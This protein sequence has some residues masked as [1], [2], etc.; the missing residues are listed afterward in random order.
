MKKKYEKP[1]VRNLTGA[2]PA[3]GGTQSCQTGN[4]ASQI[5]QDGDYDGGLCSTGGHHSPS[6]T[7]TGG[8][9]AGSCN[10][11]GDHAQ[12]CSF[13]DKAGIVGGCTVGVA[14]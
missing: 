5:C 3:I 13:G 12:D 9:Q 1:M 6:T 7:C 11:V 2:M 10:P 14:G 4:A 8:E